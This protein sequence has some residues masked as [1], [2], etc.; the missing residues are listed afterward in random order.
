MLTKLKESYHSAV[1]SPVQ[2][3]NPDAIAEEVTIKSAEYQWKF[4]LAFGIV[5]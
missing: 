1:H 4:E 5:L 3:K 2:I